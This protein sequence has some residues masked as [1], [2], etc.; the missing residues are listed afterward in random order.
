MNKIGSILLIVLLAVSITLAE[1]SIQADV[2]RNQIGPDDVIDYVIRL[3]GSGDLPNL[4]L[5]TLA[6]FDIVGTSRMSR[7]NMINGA[8]TRG[9]E[10][11][12]QL[13]PKRSGTLNIPAFRVDAEGKAYSTQPI[14]IQVSGTR[15][16]VTPVKTSSSPIFLESSTQ[17]SRYYVGEPILYT[18]K[19]YNQLQLFGQ[20][21]IKDPVFH[22]LTRVGQKAPLLFFSP[23]L[24]S[25]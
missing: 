1:F 8:I 15:A 20:P 13:R 9:L 16:P 5:P 22:N 17:K 6:D 19:I 18:L 10:L 2:D 25:K 11:H 14:S 23:P 24:F 3:S 21:S 12:H 7:F 4:R